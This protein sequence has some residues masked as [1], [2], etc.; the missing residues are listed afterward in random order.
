MRDAAK[1]SP[2]FCSAELTV[3]GRDGDMRRLYRDI[4]P[5]GRPY[6]VAVLANTIGRFGVSVHLALVR[7]ELDEAA[8][9]PA[10]PSGNWGPRRALLLVIP[11]LRKP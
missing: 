1:G 3:R 4:E 8:L 9:L 5:V 10:A 7:A 2:H 6:G 11:K